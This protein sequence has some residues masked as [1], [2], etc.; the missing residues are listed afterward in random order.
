MKAAATAPIATVVPASAVRTG[1][2]RPP[3][4]RLERHP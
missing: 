2:P 4:A 1:T 3:A